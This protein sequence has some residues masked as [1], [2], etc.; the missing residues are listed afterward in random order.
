MEEEKVKEEE[1]VQVEEEEGGEVC[2]A[3]IDGIDYFG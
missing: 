2:K 1:P 3:M